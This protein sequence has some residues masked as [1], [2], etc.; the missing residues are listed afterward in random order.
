[1]EEEKSNKQDSKDID[2]LNIDCHCVEWVVQIIIW[3]YQIIMIIY[4]VRYG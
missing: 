2:D 4:L 3:I 1:M